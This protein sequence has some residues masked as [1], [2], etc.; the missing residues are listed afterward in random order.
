MS[1]EWEFWIYPRSSCWSSCG[2]IKG[3]KQRPQ[4]LATGT[5]ATA[6]AGVAWTAFP[7]ASWADAIHVLPRR[8]RRHEVTL[9]SL[10]LLLKSALQAGS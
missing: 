9:L 1:V 3:A 2:D 4:S 8:K 6:E 5:P 10:P 7:A